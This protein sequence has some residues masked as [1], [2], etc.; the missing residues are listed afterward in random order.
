MQIVQSYETTVA[1]RDQGYA[2]QFVTLPKRAIAEEYQS[3]L[4]SQSDLLGVLGLEQFTAL[5]SLSLLPYAIVV[6]LQGNDFKT[7]SDRLQNRDF[8]DLPP[9]LLTF[10]EY[11]SFARVV[12]FE[13]SPVDFQSIAG[14][15][16]SGSPL[17]IGV[18]IGITA[19]AGATGPVLL[20]AVAAGIILCYVTDAVGRGLHYRIL[21]V[22]GVP[23]NTPPNPSIKPSDAEQKEIESHE[24]AMEKIQRWKERAE[25]QHIDVKKGG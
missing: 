6:M 7:A 14:I 21:K 12:P 19:A 18:L 16:A 22:M 24:R 20:G 4:T 5:P 8:G 11:A 13:E 3:L 17:G 10:A 2:V 25:K 1:D 15:I 9:E 23:S